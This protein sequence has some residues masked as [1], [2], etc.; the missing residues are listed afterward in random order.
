MLFA[1][2]ALAGLLVGDVQLDANHQASSA[3]LHHMRQLGIAN[4]LHQVLAHLCSI[5][6]EL[7]FLDDVEHGDGSCTVPS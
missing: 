4:S 7:L 1:D 6:H 2:E 5:L 3:H